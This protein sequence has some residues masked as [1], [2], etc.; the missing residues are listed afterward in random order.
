M[1]FPPAGDAQIRA[2]FFRGDQGN[3]IERRADPAMPAIMCPA[4]RQV[5]PFC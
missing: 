4:E 5:E 2:R 3:E 1:N